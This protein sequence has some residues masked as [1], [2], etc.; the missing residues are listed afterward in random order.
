MQAV[1]LAGG[2]GTR[3]R[4][5]VA[6]LPK[7]MAPVA[8]RPFLEYV[9]DRLVNSGVARVALATGYLSEAIESHF[10][11]AYRGVPIVYSREQQPLGTGGAITK[12]LRALP[13]QTTLVLNGDTWLDVDLAA[14]QGWCLQAPA[15]PGIVLRDVPDVSRFGA[16]TLDGQRIVAFGEKQ[17]AGRG[18]INAGVYGLTLA[19]L[20]GFGLPEVFS[21]ETDFFQRCGSTLTLR[22]FP[23][24]G[25]FIDIGVPEE[26]D[27]AQ[28]ELP[29]WQQR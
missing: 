27:R 5:R 19:H 9:L 15:S 20:D 28:T 25:S 23:C 8:G 24:H 26:F 17:A 2:F 1:V 29:I 13:A 12:A 6:D 7:P 18:Y 3:L 21:I 11:T 4:A 16:V 14:F 10:G 22:G